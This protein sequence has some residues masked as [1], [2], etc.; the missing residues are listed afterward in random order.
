MHS[1]SRIR[2]VQDRATHSENMVKEITRDIQQLDLAKKNLTVSITTL[3]N[4]TLMMSSIDHLKSILNLNGKFKILFRNRDNH[5]LGTTS[6]ATN[7]FD[8]MKDDK[9]ITIPYDEV[10]E[11]LV[12]SKKILRQLLL[13]YPDIPVIKDLNHDMQQIINELNHGKLQSDIRQVLMVF[14]I[15]IWYIYISL[16]T[17]NKYSSFSRIL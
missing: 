6:N 11:H 9:E 15:Y 4:L 8:E 14:I 7:P 16:L 5:N 17:K 10:D 13:Q 3:N 12:H 1:L 2:D